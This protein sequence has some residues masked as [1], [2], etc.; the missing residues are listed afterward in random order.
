MADAA[1]KDFDLY[2]VF[3]W[4]TPRNRGGGKRRYAIVYATR[5][6]K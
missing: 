5:A 3:G 4:I 6:N 1:E 2:V